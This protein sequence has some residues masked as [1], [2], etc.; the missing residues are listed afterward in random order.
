MTTE[1]DTCR[2]Y[3]VPR[4][5]SAGWDSEPHSIAEQRSITDG[6]VIPV[7]K[8]FVRKP[9]KRVDYLLRYAR[10]F[11]LAVVEAKASYKSA[12]DAVQQAR[13]Y[14]ETLDLKYAYATNGIEII[15]IDYFAGTEKRVA[16]FPK[17]EEL[18]RR[19]QAGSRMDTPERVDHLLAPFNTVGGKP[20][21]YYQQIA[22]NRTV[23][24][25]LAGKKRLLLTMATGTGKTIVAFQIFWKLWSTRWN[26]TGEHRK[27]RILFLADRSSLTTRKT[28]PLPLSGTPATRSNPAISSKAGRCISP[29]IRRLRRTSA[30]RGFS[31]TIHRTSSTS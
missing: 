1:A 15:E 11:P 23:E 30:G 10:D 21:R 28:K 19:Y 24:S 16:D 22:I 4:L 8:G 13:S 5:Q 9:P 26:K 2:K 27:P 29:S 14:A 12:T 25:I 6:R 31:G 3:V 17:P 20:P 7:G 18:W